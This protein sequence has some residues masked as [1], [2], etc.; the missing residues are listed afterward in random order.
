M[1]SFAHT[2]ST[3]ET[4]FAAWYMQNLVLYSLPQAA[5]KYCQQQQWKLNFENFSYVFCAYRKYFRKSCW[6]LIDAEL[7]PL[8]TGAYCALILLIVTEKSDFEIFNDLI[9]AYRK[10]FRKSCLQTKCVEFYSV[11]PATNCL[12]IS[13]TVLML[14]TFNGIYDVIFVNRK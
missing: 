14:F 8:F 2:G 6:S 9:R 5:H 3:F 12:S 10:Y 7:S 13:L 1:T 4:F 11:L